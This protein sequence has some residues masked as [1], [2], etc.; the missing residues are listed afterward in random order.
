[1]KSQDNTQ[2]D[3]EIK[4]RL[5]Q[6]NDLVTYLEKKITS[7]KSFK[8][9]IEALL[10]EARK[11]HHSS[12]VRINHIDKA[13]Q[14]LTQKVDEFK[15]EENPVDRGLAKIDAM[16]APFNLT[17]NGMSLVQ[18]DHKKIQILATELDQYIA[19][20]DR[21][22]NVLENPSC[23]TEEIRALNVDRVKAKSL[24]LFLQSSDR[25]KD[26]VRRR[27]AYVDQWL[28]HKTYVD[29]WLNHKTETV[30]SGDSES[31]GIKYYVLVVDDNCDDRETLRELFLSI[32]SETTPSMD[33]Q[34]AKNGKEAVYLHL[35]GASFDMIVMDNLMPVMNGIEATKQ[36]F[37]MGVI[38]YFVGVGDDTVSQAFLDAGI[39]HYIEK[40]LTPEKIAA[41]FCRELLDQYIAEVNQKVKV[42]ENPSS[43]REE[44][45]AL[46]VVRVKADSL[47]LFL[48]SGDRR[49]DLEV[50]RRIA[51]VNQWLNHK[52]G[53]VNSG[54]SESEELVL[55]KLLAC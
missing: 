34:V 36:L 26:E 3:L 10:N 38:S 32:K 31:E 12:T 5:V 37:G 22:V 20:I 49:K 55:A 51:Y 43:M 13:R 47:K 2:I 1:M 29:Q 15:K 17:G 52:T 7:A 11:S 4:T 6:L 24:K 28:N 14:L 45:K 9:E 39:D 42:L 50:R 18:K 41:V 16:G 8:A 19:G 33:V 40:P 46:D 27:I 25:R 23:L 53:S 35:A 54:D 21:R 30:K 44:I 48:Q